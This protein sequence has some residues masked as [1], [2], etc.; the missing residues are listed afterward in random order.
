MNA[1][2][3]AAVLAIALVHAAP[4]WGD[5]EILE[6]VS[7]LPSNMPTPL[8]PRTNVV[9]KRTY[10][11]CY[12]ISTGT[13]NDC[14]FDMTIRGLTP[15]ATDPVNNGGHNHDFD[16][17]PVGSLSIVSPFVTGPSRSQAGQT[18][19]NVFSVSHE[20][21]IVSGKID[22][23]LN[24]RVPPGWRTVF[25]RSC[26]ATQTS[27]CFLTTIDVGVPDLTSLP[28]GSPFYVKIRRGAPN[29]EDSAAY[30]GTA[31]AISNLSAIAETYSDMTTLLL[32]VNDMSLPRGG[33][34]DHRSTFNPPH[35]WHRTGQSADINKPAGQDCR[36]AYDIKVAVMFVMP[37]EAGSFF[38]TRRGFPS[39]GRFLC[40]TANDN[41]IHI[42]FDVVPPP[43][44]VE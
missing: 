3:I 22:V 5:D 13:L 25:P 39:A 29:H 10:I 38:A 32:S 33:V 28:D 20:M 11:A 4:V 18:L 12:D 16:T 9:R 30:F 7:V 6:T 26:D 42:D 41:N 8:G 43:S 35:V 36:N 27:W 21:P 24:L 17:H 15:Q 14:S 34:F 1:K 2:S 44:P 19:S 23:R 31:D 40:E 37:P